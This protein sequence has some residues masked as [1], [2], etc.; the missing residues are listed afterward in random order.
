MCLKKI[1]NCKGIRYNIFFNET[2]QTI[3]F[4]LLKNDINMRKWLL[5]IFLFFVA[6][7][8][9]N[10]EDIFEGGFYLGG[11]ITKMQDKV[12]PYDS[13]WGYQAG[14]YVRAGITWI[15]FLGAIEYSNTGTKYDTNGCFGLA[16]GSDE[17]KHTSHYSSSNHYITLPLQVALGYWE[18]CGGLTISGGGYIECGVYGQ[19]KV[20]FNMKNYKNGMFSNSFDIDVKYNTF[21]SD[22]YQIKRFDVGWM[23]GAQLGLGPNVRIGVEYRKGLLNLSQAEN[24]SLKKTNMCFNL[25]VGFPDE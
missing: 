25:I 22:D 14:G 2:G 5:A 17:Q 24:W 12:F 6:T 19:S 8:G 10:A 16:D 21:G 13:R 15:Q 4:A 23:I 1:Q 20:K 7:P 9:V 3:I 11:N 18:E